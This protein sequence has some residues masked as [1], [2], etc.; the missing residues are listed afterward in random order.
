[1]CKIYIFIFIYIYEY[2]SFIYIY[3]YI[4][5]Y[6]YGLNSDQTSLKTMECSKK[7]MILFYSFLYQ[8]QG[9]KVTSFC[10]VVITKPNS[11]R[12]SFG[13]PERR[14]TARFLLEKVIPCIV[15]PLP[16][17]WGQGLEGKK[18]CRTLLVWE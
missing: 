7:T 3:L 5:P 18:K 11:P 13:Q 12:L 15:A 14:T 4:S 1:M 6:I 9:A 8:E 10:F 16:F 17:I 2:I